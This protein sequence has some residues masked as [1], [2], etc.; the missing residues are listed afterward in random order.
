MTEES[1]KYEKC[2]KR[3][4]HDWIVEDNTEGLIEARVKLVC[5]DLSLIHI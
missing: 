3:G 2:K 5:K 1:K 4:S